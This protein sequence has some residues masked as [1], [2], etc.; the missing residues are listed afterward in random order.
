MTLLK[1]N[2]LKFARFRIRDEFARI[3]IEFEAN[4]HPYQEMPSG[5][6]RSEDAWTGMFFL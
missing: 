1:S 4:L 2:S 6:A 5:H 3:Q